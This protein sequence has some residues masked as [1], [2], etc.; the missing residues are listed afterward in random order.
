MTIL[1]ENAPH[2]IHGT[3]IFSFICLT[4]MVDQEVNIPYIE[5]LGTVILWTNTVYVYIYI[6]RGYPGPTDSGK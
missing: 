3:G 1:C 5:H 2:R 4:F 6:Y